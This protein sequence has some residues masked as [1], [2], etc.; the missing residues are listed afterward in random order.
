MANILDKKEDVL[1]VELTSWGRR[2]LGSGK[3]SPKYFSFFDTSVIYDA[4]YQDISEDTNSI[5]QR[6]INDDLTFGALSL[7]KDT[8]KDSLGTS[9]TINDYAPA[10]GL[11]L[12][13]GEATQDISGS[14][15]AKNI[16]DISPIEYKVSYNIETKEA[17][18]DG[19]WV[20]IKLEELNIQ[21]DIKNFEIEIVTYDE[22]SNG[23]DKLLERKLYF[24]PKKSNV[25]DDLIYEDNEL[26]S[27]YFKVSLTEND[28][29]Y[30]YD[31][32][33]DDEIDNEYIV[34]G[35]K[36]LSTKVEGTY[37]SNYT[38]P[39]EVSIDPVTGGVTIKC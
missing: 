3:F 13:S 34:A 25:I 36:T 27:N 5:Q 16:F 29:N 10:W 23:S 15:Y 30:Y 21:D 17:V 24:Q 28:I 31:I 33:V 32:L 20:L 2:L 8:Y 39:V 6:I 1:K 4:A 14:S 35:E 9:D 19:D 11:Y 7:T 22:I 18:V 38:G 26:P 37:S 12:L